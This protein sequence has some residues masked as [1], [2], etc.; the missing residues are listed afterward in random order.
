M[1]ERTLRLAEPESKDLG[2]EEESRC[3][4]DGF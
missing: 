1:L 3:K 2:R 4:R